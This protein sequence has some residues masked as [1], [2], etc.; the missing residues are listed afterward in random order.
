MYTMTV[1]KTLLD[2]SGILS[3]EELNGLPSP[4]NMI[5][6]ETQIEDV[7]MTSIAEVESEIDEANKENHSPDLG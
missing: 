7:N 3:D 2:R 1:N 6:P 4:G 5:L